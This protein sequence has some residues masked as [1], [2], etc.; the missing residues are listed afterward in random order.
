MLP[1]PQK[2]FLKIFNGAI[3]SEGAKAARD[4]GREGAEIRKNETI[5]SGF[6]EIRIRYKRLKN[7]TVCVEWE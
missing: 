2:K 7:L 3:K 1:R 6:T 4:A 5:K